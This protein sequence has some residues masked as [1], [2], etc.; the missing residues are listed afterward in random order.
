[1]ARR[2]QAF[3][4]SLEGRED[5]RRE[6]SAAWSKL[7]GQEQIALQFIPGVEIPAHITGQTRISLCDMAC[8]M[9]HRKAVAIAQA[10]GQDVCLVLEDDALPL[11]GADLMR[12][13]DGS[14]ATTTLPWHSVNLGG[15]SAQW[16]PSTPRLRAARVAPGLI[17][18]KGMVTTHAIL[19]HARMFDDVMCSVPTETE[20]ANFANM[21]TNP[22]PYDQWLASYGLQLTPD[23][24]LFTQS[25]SS[26]DILGT[27]HG[28]S[29][30]D[31]IMKTYEH[32]RTVVPFS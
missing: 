19:Y 11:A 12:F 2:L 3:C 28:V 8:A 17:R 4:I 32:I 22:R 26:S 18:V 5:R 13:M 27:P 25:G 29:V 10:R 14:L 1:M 24:P 21:L 30:H 20:F 9:G 23:A 31:L 6:F 15:C 16:R 7:K